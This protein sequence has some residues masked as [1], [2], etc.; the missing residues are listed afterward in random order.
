MS[1]KRLLPLS[2]VA[3]VGLIFASFAVGGEIPNIDAPLNEI[4]SFYTKHD[5]DQMLGGI[6]SAYGAFFF[7]VFSTTV[8]G[9]LRRARGEAGGASALSFAGGITATLGMCIFAG[10]TFALSDTPEKLNPVALQALNALSD[11]LFIPLA[12]GTA[13]FLLGTGIGVV[14]TAAL[15]K[16]LGWVAIALGV[17]AI[18][19][20]G[21][22]AFM[23][24]GVWTLIASVL[25]SIRADTA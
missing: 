22:F 9:V 3:A 12:V 7:L 21:F 16:W 15:P 2:G 5:S 23:G 6:L 11:D 14:K 19:P 18:T 25:L 10:I 1:A 20:I 24:L 13:A 17:L 4:V 8:A